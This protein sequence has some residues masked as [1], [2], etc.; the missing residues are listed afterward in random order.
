M[1]RK[2]HWSG[3]EAPSVWPPDRYEVR[4]TFA[5]PDYAMNDRYHFAEFA[6]EAARRARDIGLARQIQVIRLSDGAVLFDLLTGR[7]VPIAEW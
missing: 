2:P 7:E 4:C 5:P 3:T 1:A 6:Y